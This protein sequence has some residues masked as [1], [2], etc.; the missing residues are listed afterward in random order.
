MTEEV[1]LVKDINALD[2][3]GKISN[4]HLIYEIFYFSYVFG[5]GI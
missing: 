2:F 5:E 3:V 1:L 4:S